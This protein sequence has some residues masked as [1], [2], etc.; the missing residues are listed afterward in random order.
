MKPNNERTG[1]KTG[2]GAVGASLPRRKKVGLVLAAIWLQIVV[3]VFVVVQVSR[4]TTPVSDWMDKILD[5]LVR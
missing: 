3:L 1:G 4:L 5:L 2:A